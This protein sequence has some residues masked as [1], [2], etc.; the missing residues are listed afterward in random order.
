MTEAA[1]DQAL[2]CIMRKETAALK[3]FAKMQTEGKP[4]GLDRD[5]WHNAIVKRA[6]L[7]YGDAELSAAQKYVRTIEKDPLGWEL[8]AAL[9]AAPY[10]EAKEALEKPADIHKSV[11]DMHGRAHGQMHAKAIDAQRADPRASYA[12]AYARVYSDPK[13]SALRAQVK[14]EHLAA[15]MRAVSSGA[16]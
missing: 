2:D 9:K 10:P 15:T 13:N 12:G 11:A 3:M 5:D 14:A 8:Y 1:E 7:R 16:A 4:T 6:E